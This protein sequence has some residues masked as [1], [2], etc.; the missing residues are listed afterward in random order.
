MAHNLAVFQGT[1]AM[2]SLFGSS[3]GQILIGPGKEGTVPSEEKG[4]FRERISLRDHRDM[5]KP[6]RE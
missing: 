3:E 2:W 6:G 1:E 5:R 4:R